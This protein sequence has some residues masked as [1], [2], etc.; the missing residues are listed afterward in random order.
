VVVLGAAWPL[1]EVARRLGGPPVVGLTHGLEAGLCG[2]G[3]GALISRATAPLAAVT[4]ISDFTRAELAPHL[5]ADRVVRVPPGVDPGVFHPGID[6]SRMRR[7]WGVP[8]GAPLV[9]CVSRLVARKGQDVLLEAW[10]HVARAHPDAWLAIVGSG[11]RG[12]R[13]RAT[14]AGLDRVVLPGGVSWADLP[15]AYAAADVFVMPCRTRLAG[16]DVEGLG[17]VYLEAQACGVP[18]IAGRSG[19]APEAVRDGQTGLTVD[20]TDAADV[21]RA[22]RALLADPAG[23]RGM[24]AAGRRWVEEAWS[25]DRIAGDFRGLLTDVGRAV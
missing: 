20:G 11:P 1:G 19:G 6:G 25:W 8:D 2:V 4:T 17:I 22:V 9:A 7:G 3:L 10:P 16:T 18:V 5:R 13:L 12:A 15:A 23:A 21:A 14:A 24:G